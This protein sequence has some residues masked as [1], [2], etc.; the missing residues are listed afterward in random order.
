LWRSIFGNENRKPGTEN[1][2]RT[3]NLEPR[4]RNP[5]ALLHRALPFAATGLVANLQLRV[6]PLMLGAMATPAE[7]GWYGAASR[8]GRAVKL[9]P[10]AV[11]A[12]AL[13]VLSHE[14]GRD[15][16]GAHRVSRSIG[17]A[18]AVLSSGAAI[19]LALLAAPLMR[20][21]FGAPFAAAGPALVWIAI[22][23]MPSLSNSSRK[24]FLFA[25]SG[26]AVVLRWSTVA[27]AA[28]VASAAILIPVFGAA[29]AAASIALAEAV[30]W[31]PLQRAG[32]T[33]IPPE[34]VRLKADATYAG[35]G[36]SA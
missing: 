29:G 26:E 11:F 27:L 28:H 14:Y 9:A 35:I 13:P 8:V 25:A 10:Q 22:G 5:I 12:G 20:L 19:A 21:L 30:I 16:T 18:L 23:L 34:E 1:R 33:D 3:L 4:T 32:A 15:R 2:E 36:R 24:I 6:A 31:L 7:L 17:R